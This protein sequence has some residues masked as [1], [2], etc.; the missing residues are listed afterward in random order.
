MAR[1]SQNQ[2][3]TQAIALPAN[4][5]FVV[6]FE[7]APIGQEVLIV[8]RIEHIASGRRARFASWKE[9]RRFVEQ[10]LQQLKE[11]AAS[12]TPEEEREES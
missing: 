6:Q 10:E 1:H 9:L 4:R 3:Q 11:A 7:G 8:G 5:A 2:P 12:S